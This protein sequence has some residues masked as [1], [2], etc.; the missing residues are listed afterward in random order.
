MNK[1]NDSQPVGNQSCGSVFRNPKDDYAARLIESC[2][3]KGTTVGGAQ[4]STKHANFIINLGKAT[5]KDIEALI[6]KIRTTVEN[7]CGVSLIP[8]VKIIGEAE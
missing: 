7:N 4:V 5:A 1:R 6:N 8:E 3:L 2:E